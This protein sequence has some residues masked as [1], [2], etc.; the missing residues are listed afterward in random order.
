VGLCLLKNQIYLVC[1][2]KTPVATFQTRKVNQSYLFQKLATAPQF[3]GRGIGSFCLK[4]IERLARYEKCTETI[5]EVYDKSKHAKRF[6]EH[7]GYVVY[8][9]TDTLNYKELKLRKEF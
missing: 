1:D 5:C 3:A 9:K 4:E 6:Y 7:Q 2:G 8:G